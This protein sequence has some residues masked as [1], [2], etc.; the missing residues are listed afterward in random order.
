MTTPTRDAA[1]AQH[2]QG[3]GSPPA[4]NQHSQSPASVEAGAV[5]AQWRQSIQVWIDSDRVLPADGSFLLATLDR[6][7]TGLAGENARAVQAGIERF[8][9]QVQALIEAGALEPSDGHPLSEAAAAMA[10]WLSCA[11]G[12][13]E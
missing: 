10:A 1:L 4:G 8:V 2:E 12:A 5:I 7:R 3:T 13:G 11:D 6:A 9:G